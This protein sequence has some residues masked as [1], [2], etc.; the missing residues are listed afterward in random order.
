MVA[1]SAEGMMVAMLVLVDMSVAVLVVLVAR[2]A[3]ARAAA[4]LVEDAS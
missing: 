3:V 1:H 2:A 4:G